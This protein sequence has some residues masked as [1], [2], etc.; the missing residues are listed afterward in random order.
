MAGLTE[1]HPGSVS[2]R[3]HA[4]PSLKAAWGRSDPHGRLCD[5]PI[6][7]PCQ[8]GDRGLEVKASRLA[9]YASGARSRSLPPGVTRPAGSQRSRTGSGRSKA[10]PTR[11]V[12]IHP[13]ERARAPFLA[14][15][16]ESLGLEGEVP[17]SPLST[18]QPAPRVTC[19]GEGP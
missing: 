10:L 1:E 3:H 7:P 2:L 12:S 17:S 14:M 8:T 11:E 15:V 18:P 19:P 5:P 4:C 13:T 9:G 16:G 6:F